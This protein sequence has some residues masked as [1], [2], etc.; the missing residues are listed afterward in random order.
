MNESED[1][2]SSFIFANASRKVNFS[3]SFMIS[4][5]DACHIRRHSI[6]T[7]LGKHLRVLL[8]SI[9]ADDQKEINSSKT[10]EESIAVL[11]ATRLLRN[12]KLSAL[13]EVSSKILEI[14]EKI[15]SR[16]FQHI[17]T[18]HLGGDNLEN[19]LLAKLQNRVKDLSAD[20]SHILNQRL[21]KD[22][23]IIIMRIRSKTNE[24]AHAVMEIRDKAIVSTGEVII[25]RNKAISFAETVENL[26]STFAKKD[27]INSFRDEAIE[28]AENVVD[29][30]NRLCNIFAEITSLNNKIIAIA[31]A[32]KI[33][34]KLPFLNG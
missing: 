30:R 11:D 14:A 10:V 13:Q 23:D 32:E 6:P 8:Q 31:D 25:L 19:N 21:E 2:K 1:I 9:V 26:Q 28:N 3:D 4:K 15:N 24:L 33:C 5:A 29:L 16:S 27:I 18:L 17:I 7:L 20:L 22:G 12:L 34:T